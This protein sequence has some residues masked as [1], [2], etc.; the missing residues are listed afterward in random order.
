MND[1]IKFTIDVPEVD[2]P[3]NFLDLS[4]YVENENIKYSW[5]TKEAHSNITLNRESWLPRHVKS[6]FIIN[7]V[8]QVNDKCSDIDNK[9]EAFQKLDKR[10]QE[11]GYKNVHSNRVVKCK[12]KKISKSAKKD[13]STYLK[14]T[15]NALRK[16]LKLLIST[17]F[18]YKLSINQLNIYIKVSIAKIREINI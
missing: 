15:I 2:K 3:L 14:L 6:N 8:K 5:Y 4:I 10:F 7:T 9:N 16:S 17:T 18:R 13:K 12:D 11:N 1:N